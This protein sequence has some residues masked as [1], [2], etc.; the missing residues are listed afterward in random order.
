MI[1]SKILSRLVWLGIGLLLVG[2]ALNVSASYDLHW[3][4]LS[5]GGGIAESASYVMPATLGQQAAGVASSANYRLSSG[6]WY[7][8][9]LKDTRPIVT[10]LLFVPLLRRSP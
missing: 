10:R 7:G 5:M 9:S 2:V 8:L 4:V 6:F 3:R 1:R